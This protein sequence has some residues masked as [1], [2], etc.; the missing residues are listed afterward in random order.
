MSLHPIKALEQIIE[1]YKDYLLTE[2]RA[3]DTKLKEAL[4][5]ELTKPGFIAQEPFYQAH[6]PFKT[7]KKWGELPILDKFSNIL[8][9]RSKSEKCYS[10][11]SEAIE[12]LLGASASPLV[13][14]TGTGSGKTECFLVPVIQNAINHY[15]KDKVSTL[16]AILLYPMNALAND[17]KERIEQYLEAT[18]Y[19][20]KIRVAKYDR[21]TRQ[22]ERDDLRKNPPHILLTNYMMLEYLLI[23]PKDREEIFK[24]NHCRFLVLDEVHTYRGALG[25]NIALLNRRVKQHLFKLKSSSYMDDLICVGTSATIKSDTEKEKSKEEAEQ[26]RTSDIQQFFGKLTGTEFETIKVINESLTKMDIPK[27]AQY[28]NILILVNTEK[29]YDTKQLAKAICVIAGTTGTD[30][31]KSA[32]NSCK[33]LWD[34][35]KWLISRPASIS[36]L[37]KMIKENVKERA[38]W[39]DEDIQKEVE[40]ALV[41]GGMLD[42]SSP[43]QLNIKAHR[44]VRG[45]WKFYRCTNPNCGKLYPRGE[46]H[47]TVCHSPTAPLY[48]CRN[49]GADYLRLA[50]GETDATELHPSEDP[51]EKYEWLIY[52]YSKFAQNDVHDE[53]DDEDE[54]EN[55]ERQKRSAKTSGQ[56]KGRPVLHG[57]MSVGEAVLFDEDEKKLEHKVIL[58]PARNRCLCCGAT[59]GS[60]NII[61]PV[62]L[63]TSAAL[64]VL[65]EGTIEALEEAHKDETNDDGKERLLIFSDSRQDAAHQAR[66]IKFA[67]RYDRMRR[68]VYAILASKGEMRIQDI[69]QELAYI[70]QLEKDNPNLEATTQGRVSEIAAKKM[71]AYEE[72]PLLDDLSLNT[73]FRST[74]KNLGL[75]DIRYEKLDGYVNDEG[76][77]L[78]KILNI[79]KSQI[80]Q[81]A[82]AIL[83][84]IREQG[85]L[86]RE[87]SIYNPR[88]QRYPNYLEFAF[89]QRKIVKPSGFSLNDNHQPV[90]SIEQEHIPY[91]IKRFNFWRAGTRGRSTTLQR[92]FENMM[93]RFGVQTPTVDMMMAL[94]SF[95]T[96]GQYLKPV[97]LFGFQHSYK[98]IQ[99]NEETVILKKSEEMSRFKCK[100][101]G[102]V[103]CGVS[104][105]SVCP[106]CHGTYSIFTDAELNKNRYVKRI[107]TGT[108]TSLEAE[109]HTAQVSSDDRAEIEEKF[110]TKKSDNPL[111]VLACSPTLE[112]GIDIGGLDAILL[113]NVPPRPD[114]YAQRSGRAGRRK[115]VGLIVGFARNTPH[116]QYFYDHPDE[117]I[118]GEVLAPQISL[119]NT[120]V[121]FRHIAS[122]AFGITDP[123]LQ[124]KMVSYISPMGEMQQQKV[125]ELTNSIKENKDA[126]FAAVMKSFDKSIFEHSG[127][128]EEKVKEFI[129]KLPVKI[130]D[131]LNRTRKQVLDLRKSLEIYYTELRG[132]NASVRAGNLI[133]SIL[134]LPGQRQNRGEDADDR[135]SGYPLRRFAEAGILPGYEFPSKPSTVRLLRD[136][137][138]DNLVSVNRRF[139]LLQY[140]PDSP[141]YARGSRWKVAGL[142][143]SS[144]WNPSNETDEQPYTI[145]TDCDLHYDSR[146]P[147]CPR[148]KSDKV[149]PHYRAKEYAG[150]IAMRDDMP[151]MDEEDR[152]SAKGAVNGYPQ[153]NGEVTNRWSAE[154]G[155]VLR[156]SKNEKV[157]WM[158]EGRKP[159]HNEIDSKLVLNDDSAGFLLCPSCGKQLTRPIVSNK[160]TNKKTKT[161]EDPYEHYDR[162]SIRG[163]RVEPV[164]LLA[165]EEVE[166]L[167][168]IVS[169]PENIGEDEYKVW[170]YSL[171]YALRTGMRHRYSLDGNEIEFILEGPWF[172]N[173]DGKSV[174]FASLAFVDGH[175]GGSG[176]LRKIGD[177]MDKVAADTI[178]YLKHDNC[179]TACYRCLKSYQNQRF[180]EFLRWPMIIPDLEMLSQS[181]PIKQD[182]KLGDIKDPKPWLEAYE[183]G[184]GSPL[185]LKFMKEFDKMG[186]KYRKQIAIPYDKP[187]SVADFIIEK[188]GKE[189]AVYIDGAAFHVG[190]NLRRDIYIRSRLIEVGWKL[191]ELKAANLSKLKDIMK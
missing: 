109:E 180:H 59:A 85:C 131:V 28:S 43:V 19:G 127:V 126:I 105:G 15:N 133:G 156:L 128:D 103:T 167:R 186:V 9:D 91:G 92:I 185:E 144:P 61:S 68:R 11:Q 148:C 190:A 124:G 146:M 6:R 26:K 187:I 155:W 64:K 151:V 137:R 130:I 132:E 111:N 183:A 75:L 37:I 71:R 3:K 41:L 55:D 22:A 112:M 78:S 119:G 129:E 171:G 152:I 161:E 51:S 93:I 84:R 83:D 145:C 13:V 170:G 34:L 106:Y 174:N 2:F 136:K 56:M 45:G 102:N 139:G 70:A 95:L 191:L 20:D 63:G 101:C 32:V 147:I 79:N 173:V 153:W 120:D 7:I 121:L 5:L 4:E 113:R 66:F 100:V 42:E 141:V 40:T 138:E 116:D 118:S 50:G 47:C 162:C 74:L 184:L 88:H 135:S 60:R 107:K 57:S 90:S 125:D 87:M 104:E 65:A 29:I 1:E 67:G 163:Q 53:D 160:K 46:E 76:D 140:Q 181:A 157:F 30:D 16:T 179:E 81:I 182:L 115:R 178:N 62:S 69:V 165:L 10:H 154:G 98:L 142:D 99:V 82:K 149:S 21:S 27:E 164:A 35:N 123:G 14:T 169:V 150:F 52:N 49:C 94:I 58:S 38:G 97:E 18:G 24:N 158:N 110:K 89:W 25:A 12:T 166:I 114:N 176:Y 86:S 33:I 80:Y 117:M 122:I 31:I 48:L 54:E 36:Q 96:D 17:Q 134:G 175:I 172:E 177:D 23:R 73:S 108:H 188:D 189:V 159:S 8:I 39:K 143:T 72:A 77:T 168:I 44:F